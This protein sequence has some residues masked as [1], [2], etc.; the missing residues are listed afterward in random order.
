M[1]DQAGQVI[2]IVTASG[3][4]GEMDFGTFLSIFGFND[5]GNSEACLQTLFEAFDFNGQGIF[6]PAEF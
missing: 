3:H 6:G 2:G 4:E 5:S 1:E